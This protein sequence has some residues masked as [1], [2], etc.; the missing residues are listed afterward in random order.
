MPKPQISASAPLAR[1]ESPR[2]YLCYSPSTVTSV[3][4]VLWSDA[5]WRSGRSSCIRSD[6]RSHAGT[7]RKKEATHVTERRETFFHEGLN[8]RVD[9]I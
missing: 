4:R 5:D 1:S 7:R 8:G 9:R 6:A 3:R 2:P